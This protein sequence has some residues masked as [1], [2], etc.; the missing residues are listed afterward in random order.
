[1]ALAAYYFFFGKKTTTIPTPEE[2]LK[3]VEDGTLVD[4]KPDRPNSGWT[5]GGNDKG[6]YHTF[7]EYV[8]IA[9]GTAGLFAYRFNIKGTYKMSGDGLKV[10][11]A[12]PGIQKQ[13]WWRPTKTITPTTT[14]GTTTGGNG[15]PKSATDNPTT[16]G[17][18]IKQKP[19]AEGSDWSNEA[20]GG[21]IKENDTVTFMEAVDLAFGI[22][23]NFFYKTNVIGD[24]EFSIDNFRD[25]KIGS[26]KLGFWRI[27]ET[28]SDGKGTGEV[29]TAMDAPDTITNPTIF[30][31]P[32]KNPR[33]TGTYPYENGSSW[34]GRWVNDTIFQNRKLSF[35]STRVD[36]AYGR[37]KNLV[38][39]LNVTGDVEFSND[40]FGHDPA[41]NQTK[42]GWY[43]LSK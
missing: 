3:A 12:A 22:D 30:A 10:A 39:K 38:F 15:A 8:D 11:D 18:A 33:V 14:G 28:A 34:I 19:D 35:G 2:L 1:V 37:D 7:N 24:Q 42:Y 4:P 36:V 32:Y 27:S 25:P 26:Q 9:F 40:F 16:T 20:N 41:V 17:D 31:I 29:K 23:G 5:F 21:H 43:R 6:E 13:W